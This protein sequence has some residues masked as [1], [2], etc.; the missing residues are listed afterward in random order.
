MLSVEKLKHLRL[1]QNL[2]QQNIATVCGVTKNYI[3]ILE[4]RKQNV[5]EDF[6]NSWLNAIYKL[7]SMSKDEQKEYIKN[8]KIEAEQ[9]LNKNVEGKPINNT[10]KPSKK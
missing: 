9:E 3:S 4:N 10:K 6:Y 7:G 8:L 5:N 1:L 2:T